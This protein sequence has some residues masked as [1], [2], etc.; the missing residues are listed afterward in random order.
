MTDEPTR[1]I[2]RCP[3]CRGEGE[4]FAGAEMHPNPYDYSSYNEIW[5]RCPVCA[6]DEGWP[7]WE[8]Y[9]WRRCPECDNIHYGMCRCEMKPFDEFLAQWRAAEEEGD[10]V[11]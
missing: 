7:Y 4:I 11:C 1:T 2:E 6:G 10:D 3:A 5:V 9:T 8:F